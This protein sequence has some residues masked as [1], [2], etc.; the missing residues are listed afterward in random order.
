MV[1][2]EPLQENCLALIKQI[3]FKKWHTKITIII[4]DFA[5]TTVALID[6]GA[7]LN[8]VQDGL[9]PSKYYSKTTEIFKICKWF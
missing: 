3:K 2:E 9:I 1:I 7:D 5:L 6:T 4:K 8:Y